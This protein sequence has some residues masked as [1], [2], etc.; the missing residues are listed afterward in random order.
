MFAINDM[1]YRFEIAFTTVE[2]KWWPEGHKTALV[3]LYGNKGR[4]IMRS[5][6]MSYNLF[7]NLDKV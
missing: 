5:L 1:I 6:P 3:G 7:E 2:P 4:F